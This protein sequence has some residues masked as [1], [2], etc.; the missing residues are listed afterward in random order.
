[1]KPFDKFFVEAL[2]QLMFFGCGFEFINS[3]KIKMDCDLYTNGLFDH[4]IPK[5]SVAFDKPLEEWSLIFI[6]EYSHFLQW[7]EN[8][9]IYWSDC[10]FGRDLY[11]NYIQGQEVNLSKNRLHFIIDKIQLIELDAEK[12]S[13][14]ILERW[15]FSDKTIR[16]YTKRANSYIFF[17]EILKIKN[18]WYKTAPYEVPEIIDLMNDSFYDNYHNISEDV[19]NLMLEKCF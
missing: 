9:P 18:S 10:V 7:N 19:K 12:R 8:D 16:K 6:H 1:M 5:L 2:K 14:D 15:N 3:N 11:E 4:T 13:V 17:H